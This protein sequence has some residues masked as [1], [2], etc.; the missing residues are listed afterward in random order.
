MYK[1]C[2]WGKNKNMYIFHIHIFHKVGYPRLL[3]SPSDQVNYM[4]LCHTAHV[5]CE[6]YF[7]HV[8]Y[9]NI[10]FWMPYYILQEIAIQV[11]FIVKLCFLLN[12]SHYKVCVNETN[13]S[14]G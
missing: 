3:C 6:H 2:K 11:Q 9:I 12:S 5:F 1:G 14:V 13:P 10:F 4:S 8:M 7:F